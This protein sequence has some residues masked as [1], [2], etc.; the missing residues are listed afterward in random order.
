[1]NETVPL[2]EHLAGRII[3][4]WDVPISAG[5]LKPTDDGEEV[6]ELFEARKLALAKLIKET[7]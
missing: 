1:M 4:L 3:Q 7:L 5:G 6:T 2:T